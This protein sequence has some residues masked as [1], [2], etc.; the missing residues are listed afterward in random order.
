MRWTQT[1]RW[2]CHPQ[3]VFRDRFGIA[4]PEV[5]PAGPPHLF[6]HTELEGEVRDG[7]ALRSAASSTT[8]TLSTGSQ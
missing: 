4:D 2:L 6:E 5:P 8:A 3:A 7:K 1:S